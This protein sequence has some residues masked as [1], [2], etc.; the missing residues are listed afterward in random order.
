MLVQWARLILVLQDALD[1][2]R[3]MRMLGL[4]DYALGGTSAFYRF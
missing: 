4:R 3:N 2:K 1:I